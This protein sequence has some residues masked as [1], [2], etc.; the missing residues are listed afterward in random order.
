[1]GTSVKDTKHNLTY[2]YPSIKGYGLFHSKL[3][4]LEFNDRLRVGMCSGNLTP[5]DWR[6]TS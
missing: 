1:M 6:E 2:T 4:L 3:F 5:N